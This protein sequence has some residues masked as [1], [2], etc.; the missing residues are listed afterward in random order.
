MPL[1]LREAVR[2]ALRVSANE[3]EEATGLA[4]AAD[5]NAD[6]VATIGSTVIRVE[7]KNKQIADSLLEAAEIYGGRFPDLHQPAWQTYL[8]SFKPRGARADSPEEWLD[9]YRD[10]AK[11][12]IT[13]GGN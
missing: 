5:I 11:H 3:W 10:L 12:G 8:S 9:L 6:L 13:P 2:R 7:V 1:E 4:T